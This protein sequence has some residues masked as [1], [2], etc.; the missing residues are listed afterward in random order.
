MIGWA[1]VYLYPAQVKNSIFRN[2]E[3][4]SIG[5]FPVLMNKPALMKAFIPAMLRIKRCGEIQQLMIFYLK[6]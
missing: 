3:I 5:I 6:C 2:I 1:N 4:I